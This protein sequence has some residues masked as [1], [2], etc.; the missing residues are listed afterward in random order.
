MEVAVP[1]A[2]TTGTD[3]EP[4]AVT[5]IDWIRVQARVLW[6]TMQALSASVVWLDWFHLPREAYNTAASPQLRSQLLRSG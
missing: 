2:Q 3:Q 5:W 4:K 6:P 1:I